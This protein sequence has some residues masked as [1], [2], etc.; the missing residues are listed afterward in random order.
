M[1]TEVRQVFPW[2]ARYSVG[3]PEIDEQHKRL[4]G[5]IN[6][7]QAAMLR[8]EGKTVLSRIL[9]ELIRY[10]ETHFAAEEK[11]LRARRY[12]EVAAHEQQHQNLKKQVY[13]L[14]DELRSGKVTV[15]MEV[16]HFLK[17]WLANHILGAD[18][19]YAAALKG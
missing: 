19:R 18:L 3:I 10:T 6:D 14:R 5:L 8:G 17:N 12:S 16:M 11:L 15:T 9:D 13:A 1:A 7:L 4:I 2:Q